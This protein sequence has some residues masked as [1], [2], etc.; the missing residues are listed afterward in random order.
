MFHHRLVD[1]AGIW[2]LLFCE[3]MVSQSVEQHWP[4]EIH[5]VEAVLAHLEAAAPT[6]S[7]RLLNVSAVFNK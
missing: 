1:M 4:P 5:Q 7:P 6:S 2:L 3:V